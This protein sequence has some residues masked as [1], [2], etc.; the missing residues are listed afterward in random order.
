MLVVSSNRVKRLRYCMQKM[1]STSLAASP[2]TPLSMATTGTPAFC[3]SKMFTL[4]RAS[5]A[6]KDVS[7]WMYRKVFNESV[8]QLIFWKV[9]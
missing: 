2:V 5:P 1:E 4:Y 7:E 9:S 6:E 8:I 3:I